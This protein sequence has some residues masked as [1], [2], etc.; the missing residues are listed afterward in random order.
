M[1]IREKPQRL[2]YALRQAW[3][4]V[5]DEF[6][7]RTAANK[8]TGE[9]VRRFM[10]LL[11][12]KRAQS[13]AIL[14]RF[15]LPLSDGEKS[16]ALAAA[17]PKAEYASGEAEAGELVVERL[18]EYVSRFD[19]ILDAIGEGRALSREKKA[20]LQTMLRDLKGELE[21]DVKEEAA[22]RGVMTRTEEAY[23]YP[24][25][26]R[27]HAE[28]RV[29]WNSDPVRSD[30]HSNLYGAKINITHLLHQLENPRIDEQ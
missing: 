25:V 24:A 16:E 17:F 14:I 19:A 26:R 20:E 8:A 2:N 22:N 27:A 7:A 18:R 11:L 4:H 28:I 29:K 1:P 30:W 15:W 10:G 12:D 23:F 6:F 5:R 13:S 21:E 3:D 9:D